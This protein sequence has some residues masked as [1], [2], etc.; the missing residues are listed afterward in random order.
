MPM[1]VYVPA[2]ASG[3]AVPALVV[4]V[5]VRVPADGQQSDEPAAEEPVHLDVGLALRRLRKAPFAPRT[6]KLYADALRRFGAWLSGRPADDATLTAYLDELFDRG[7]APESGVLVVAAVARAALECARAGR[8]CS[9]DPVGP[10]TRERLERFRRDGAGRGRGQV[11]GLTWDEAELMCGLAEDAGDPRGKR[12]AAIIGVAADGLMRVSEVSGLNAGDVSF[13]PDGTAEA[14][15]RRSKTDQRGRGDVA[16][17][18]AVAAER[19]R[20]W[21]EAAGVERGPL[22][23]PVDRRGRVSDRR[24][25]P[26]SVRAAIKRRAAR[27]G[28]RG[29]VSGHSLHIGMAQ[30][31]AEAGVSL[32]ELQRGPL[33]V[34]GDAGPLRARPRGVPGRGGAAARRREKSE[35]SCCAARNGGGRVRLTRVNRTILKPSGIVTRRVAKFPPIPRRTRPNR[36]DGASQTL[37]GHVA[38]H[39]RGTSRPP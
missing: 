21:M 7:L 4:V 34:A 14:L 35:K 18:G 23:R 2:F 24:L 3:H 31:L 38:C 20:C 29:R 13:L 39:E 11:R 32:A 15:V 27:A 12:D 8:E 28:I 37:K 1:P 30:R 25:G 26:D 9:E 16:H 5:V 19:L 33:E 10:S 6:R 36:P 17:I 22:F